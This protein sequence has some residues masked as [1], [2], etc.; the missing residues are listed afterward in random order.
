[1]HVPFFFGLGSSTFKQYY[2]FPIE[3]YPY[4][5][6]MHDIFIGFIN[7]W[8][9]KVTASKVFLLVLQYS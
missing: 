5:T 4:I 9:R 3:F 6:S 2:N 7:D 1:M 8:N